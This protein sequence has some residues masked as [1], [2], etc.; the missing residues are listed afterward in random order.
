MSKA[1][2]K[3][4]VSKKRTPV[5]KVSASSKV[6]KKQAK[7]LPT[8]N[9]FV[10]LWLL[11]RAIGRK[12]RAAGRALRTRSKNFLRRRP[13]RSFRLTKR[14]DYKRSLKMPGYFAFTLEVSRLLWRNKK[15]FIWMAI[16][17]I[18][19]MV[20]FGLMGSQDIY[21]QLRDLMM[22][23]A[24]DSLFD[25]AIGEV[26]KAGVLLFATVTT[27]ITG[28][29]E[30]LQA[31]IAGFLALYVWLTTVWL[32]RRL[33]ANKKVKLRDGLYSAGAP[34][35]PT[36]LVV[37]IL[38]VQLVPAAAATIVAGAAWQ[39]GIVDGGA[40]S[41]AIALG[42]LLIIVLSLYWVTSTFVSLIVVTLPGMYPIQA[43][44]IAGDL[45]V[46]RR[47][48][49]L[50]R[51]LWLLFFVVSWWVVL[52]V[53][54]ILFDGWIKS[55]FEQ[56]DWLPIVPVALLL[57]STISIVWACTYVYL[58]YRKMVDDDASPA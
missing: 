51:I 35:L 55:I 45:V 13:H 3:K 26:G 12:L 52:M 41:M 53:P 46:G 24:P 20:V 22:T 8:Y 21:G 34:I 28:E 30:P 18:V 5:K 58:L 10:L 27:G 25:G 33:V 47:L 40:A 29:L 44:T 49:V 23:T 48:R 42:L 43:L 54:I 15:V 9:P 39:S 32:L 4:H 6:P 19:L 1:N 36:F 38:L 2:P 50:Y 56:I 17:Y 31:V 7:K 16:V 57:F 14:R 11:V 37:I